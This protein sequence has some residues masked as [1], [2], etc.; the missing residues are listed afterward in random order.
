MNLRKRIEKLE[1]RYQ[2]K[3]I[4]LRFANGRTAEFRIGGSSQ[5]FADF[6]R[7]VLTDDYSAP[8]FRELVDGIRTCI[9]YS[10]CGHWLD[11]IRAGLPPVGEE[12]SPRPQIPPLNVR[13]AALGPMPASAAKE[14]PK[15]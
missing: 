11:V 3:S 5:D 2:A 15:W 12:L 7:K 6:F 14:T 4:I 1:A 13:P 10:G 8:E 9:S